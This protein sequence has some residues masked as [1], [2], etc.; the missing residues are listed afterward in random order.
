MAADHDNIG[1]SKTWW[2]DKN[3][4]DTVIPDYKPIQDGHL[5]LQRWETS[6]MPSSHDSK[7]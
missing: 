6:I 5:R 3:Q 7:P 1:T 2:K 4:W